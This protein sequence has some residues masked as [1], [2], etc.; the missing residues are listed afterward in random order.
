MD[1]DKIK[2]LMETTERIELIGNNIRF[3][4]NNLYGYYKIHS[5]ARFKKLEA[6]QGFFARFEL[7]NGKKGWLDRNGKEYLDL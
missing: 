4:E 5:K 6:F 1:F 7:P 3:K 2:E